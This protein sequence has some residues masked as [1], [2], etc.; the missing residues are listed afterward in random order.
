MANQ[1]KLMVGTSALAALLTACGG[2][3]SS[4]PAAEASGPTARALP[5]EIAAIIDQQNPL[6]D[7]LCPL[8]SAAPDEFGNISPEACL[9]EGEEGAE[10]DGGEQLSLE[11]IVQQFCP[12]T[13]QSIDDM[14]S[15]PAACLQ[16]AA[17]NFGD[18]GNLI[19]GA[20]PITDAICPEESADGVVDP[21]NCFAEAAASGNLPGGGDGGETGD[22]I[23]EQLCPQTG[24]STPDADAPTACLDEASRVY[25][26]IVDM[27]TAT[28]PLTEQLCPMESASGRYDPD[29][30]F[31]E[32]TMGAG[33][34]P[35]DG[36]GDGGDGSNPFAP[37]ME[38][39][40]PE[41]AAAPLSEST[42]IDC[43]S[44][45]GGNFQEVQDL[46]TG[47]NPLTENLCPE[48]AQTSPI[49]PAACFMEAAGGGLPGGGGG[50]NPLAP[51]MEQ[52][53]PETAAAD[54]G[55]TTPIDCLTEAGSAFGDVEELIGGANPL[56][57]A[58]CPEAAQNSPID[59]AACF[60]EATAGGAPG[61][62]ENPLAPVM[63]QFCPETALDGLSETTAIDCLTEAGSNFQDVQDLLLGP[64]PLT[65]NLCPTA[66]QTSPIDP[67]ACF[68]EAAGGSGGGGENP[69]APVLEQFCPNTAGAAV[70]P[71]TPIDCLTEAG[72]AFGDVQDLIGGANP[73]TEQFCPEE[74]ADGEVDPAV[75]FEE[76]LSGGAPGGGANP[77]QP[78]LDQ[79]C[80]ETAAGE[81][82]PTTPVD[83]LAEAG[84]NFQDVQDLLLGPN[85]LTENLCPTAAQ[86]SP[87]DPAACFEEAA[88]GSGGGGE[89][90]L[91]PV[92]A[93]FCPE[94]AM[95]D[96]GPTTPIDCLTEAGAAFGDVEELIGGANPLTEALCPEAAQSSPIDPAACFMEATGGGTPG[97]GENPL[98]PVLEQFCPATTE[99]EVGPT[100][101]IDCLAEA[102]STFGNIED[103]LGGSNPLTEAF[104]PM[105]SADGSVDPATC[106]EEAIAGGG[107]GGGENPLAPVMEQFCPVTA[108]AE[109]GPNTPSDC[110]ME[111]GANLGALEELLGPLS[112]PNPLTEQVCPETSATGLVEPT[113]CF[114]ESLEAVEFLDIPLSPECSLLSGASDEG[115][116]SLTLGLGCLLE[117]LSSTDGDSNPLTDLF[118]SLLGGLL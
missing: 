107:G 113:A 21:A 87:I 77:L 13:V 99:M 30:C 19:G 47:P 73:L 91:A 82:G 66:A 59:P 57:E 117:E 69:L 53:C 41:T 70:G 54:L 38:Q 95:A 111:A 27:I 46:L 1:F 76:A 3:G 92:M 18:F 12:E 72:E 58:L 84:S 14:A 102:G 24:S 108:G 96:L 10:E 49:D 9:E 28:N 33:G 118:D 25:M 112:E 39:F 106:F 104:C 116:I 97:G 51:V 34:F 110:L 101:P 36:G 7:A 52:F 17:S 62:G 80:P 26:T 61:G 6:T 20:N 75:C 23:A 63:E 11:P 42:A 35:G 78:V 60:M 65:E 37:L 32:A 67:A 109:L 94:T 74:S 83:C 8:T 71:T 55:P 90:P 88:G 103:V 29:D 45:A 68:E 115:D 50:G 15:F 89:N 79:F 31:A 43:L 48:A 98:A 40:C 4:S 44:E 114:I 64:N 22:P 100:T 16:E 93:Q 86:T 105:E 85:P 5:P 2:G 81:V 56:T